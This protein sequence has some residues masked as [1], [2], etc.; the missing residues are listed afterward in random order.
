MT[1]ST[2]AHA[3][4]ADNTDSLTCMLDDRHWRVRG[5]EGQLSCDR[6]RVNLLVQ[7]RELLHVDTLDLY[8]SRQR[9]MFIKEA[10]AELFCEEDTIKRDLGHVLR[11]LEA[12]QDALIQQTLGQRQP[13][14]PAMSDAQR[15]EAITLL[16]D[17]QLVQRILEHL[18]ACGLVGEQDNK[19]VCYLAC[20]SRLLP[21]P[22]SVLVQ[23]SSAAGKTTLQ[24]AV[25]R[26]MPAE[27]QTRLS[28]L[29]AQSLYYMPEDRLRH[30]ILAVAEEDGLAEATY[31]LKVLQSDGKLS[32]A[33]TAWNTLARR[34]QTR[35]HQVQGPV[36]MLLTTTA[37]VP[38]AELA[39]RCLVLAV[40]EQ[41]EQTAAIHRRQRAAY[42]Q[43]PARPLLDLASLVACHQHAQRLLEPLQVVI[44]W[45]DQL[46]FRTDQTRHRRDHGKYL[47][48]IAAITLL[49]QYQRKRFTRTADG[50]P[51]KCVVASL[52]DIQLAHRL[53]GAVFG[54][55]R[56]SLM[57]Q[58][59]RL[60]A[61]LHEYVTERAQTEGVAA[62]SVR[63]SQ[64]QL[65]EA[66]QLSD[67]SLRT[68]L[69]RLVQ[70]EYVLVYRTGRGNQRLYQLLG[71]WD[72][73]MESPTHSQL[74]LV[75][76]SQLR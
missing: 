9:R 29:T 8:V 13:E 10:A 60:L 17:P 36:A 35:L 56:D 42:Q 20:V 30:K 6:L 2:A 12:Q 39:N 7:R 31:A 54:R 24:D 61:Q 57:P 63:F 18:E 4:R 25:L 76:V 73:A 33:T 69:A 43:A 16:Q 46:T 37:E 19:L 5:L 22:L 11:E 62:S 23:S 45:A 58:T 26:L 47:T 27:S 21:Q 67:R 71:A 14:V 44:P 55:H 68:H 66:L 51:Q 48:L 74:G 32:I 40:N 52:E 50:Q 49:H 72:D 53:A 75:D 41:P 65:R 28:T 1:A 59:R 15:R 70:L 34:Q 3:L 64:R 38:H